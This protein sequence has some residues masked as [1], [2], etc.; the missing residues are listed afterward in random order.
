MGSVG[1]PVSVCAAGCDS[2]IGPARAA[3]NN[4]RLHPTDREIIYRWYA[5]IRAFLSFTV[6]KMEICTA[7]KRSRLDFRASTYAPLDVWWASR[8]QKGK[9]TCGALR[10]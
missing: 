1:D 8:H 3:K 5:R 10:Y 4:F 2:P 6:E 9:Q 7:L